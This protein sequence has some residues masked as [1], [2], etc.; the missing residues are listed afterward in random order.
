MR[1]QKPYNHINI[2]GIRHV[3]APA[4]LASLQAFGVSYNPAYLRQITCNGTIPAHKHKGRWFYDTDA[5][6]A[7]L[8]IVQADDNRKTTGRIAPIDWENS[9]ADNWL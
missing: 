1:G 9:S 4:L 3:H 8:G 7:K 2:K 6:I 5:V